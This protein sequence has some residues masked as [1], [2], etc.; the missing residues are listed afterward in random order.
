MMSAHTPSLTMSGI[1]V[2]ASSNRGAQGPVSLH[3][4]FLQFA[5]APGGELPFLIRVGVLPPQLEKQP[6]PQM[7]G[8]LACRLGFSR[9]NSQCG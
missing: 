6:S 9:L 5:L 8:R 3:R 7:S 2:S 4:T 1:E